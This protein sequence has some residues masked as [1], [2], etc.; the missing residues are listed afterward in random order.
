MKTLSLLAVGVFVVGCSKDAPKDGDPAP[1][2]APS[3]VGSTNAAPVTPSAVTAPAGTGLTAGPDGALTLSWK[4]TNGASPNV[5]VSLVV[6]DQTFPLAAL[7]ATSDDGPSTVEA[8]SMKNT[9]T[10][11]S[12]LSCG[13]CPRYNGYTAKRRGGARALTLPD[14]VDSGPDTPEK[15][16]ITGVLRKPTTA[17]TLKA[18]GPASKGLYGECRPGFVQ[19]KA[20]A[21]CIRQC[22]K[23]TGCKATEK[24]ELTAVEGTDGPHKVSACVPK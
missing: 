8:C 19:K 23:G 11:E 2:N 9:G 20:G 12:R 7:D 6:G 24:C 17:T 13:V 18:T 14:G 10:G 22:L 16:K 1:K 3:A 4:I 5:N 21:P 15:P